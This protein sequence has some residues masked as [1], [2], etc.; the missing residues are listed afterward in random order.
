MTSL[1]KHIESIRQFL[2]ERPTYRLFAIAESHLSPKVESRLVEIEGFSL[3][4]QDR[5][6]DGGGV[7][8]YVHNSLKAEVLVSSCT[9]IREGTPGVPEYLLCSVQEGRAAPIFVAVIY[10]PPHIPW[11]I[12]S[13]LIDKLNLH[14]E[15]FSHKII[16]GDF[17][18]NLLLTE[19]DAKF[20][21]KLAKDL[22]LKI[23]E[24]GATHHKPNPESHTWIEMQ[25]KTHKITT[26]KSTPFL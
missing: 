11:L 16:V 6:R 14:T 8:L 7:A 25:I 12:K 17:N 13:D 4:R 9:S 21:R 10:R 26:T 19:N 20:L 5:N 3:L 1:A 2:R 24:H 15:D 23:V 22:S 18:P